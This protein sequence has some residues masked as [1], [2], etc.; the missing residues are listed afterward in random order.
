MT[1]YYFV[2]SIDELKQLNKM[3]DKEYISNEFFPLVK[4]MLKRA[5]NFLDNPDDEFSNRTNGLNG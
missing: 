3:L 5:N 2:I 1:R 4:I